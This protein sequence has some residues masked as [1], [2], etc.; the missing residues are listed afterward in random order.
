MSSPDSDN[1]PVYRLDAL[2]VASKNFYGN[3]TP[4]RYLF[5]VID[6]QLKLSNKKINII[7]DIHQIIK[8]LLSRYVI[9]HTI[10]IC[11]N[12]KRIR[13]LESMIVNYILHYYHYLK[14]K[15]TL[16]YIYILNDVN[17]VINNMEEIEKEK[18][19][20]DYYKQYLHFSD[21]KYL[22]V[23]KKLI[24]DN[25]LLPSII[26]CIP[27]TYF[28]NIPM[29]FSKFLK[30]LSGSSIMNSGHN[31]ILSRKELDVA[32]VNNQNSFLVIPN[33]KKIK[34]VGISNSENDELGSLLISASFPIQNIS[35]LISLVSYSKYYKRG[36][37]GY[38]FKKALASN[39]TQNLLNK[40][41]DILSWETY[42]NDL[43]NSTSSSKDE[44]KLVL[45]KDDI[46]NSEKIF[47]TFLCTQIDTD[48]AKNVIESQEVST[49]TSFDEL[50]AVLNEKYFK[51]CKLNLKPFNR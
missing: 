11:S 37:K 24:S 23:Y 25:A 51:N 1:I 16:G 45:Y 5:E 47:S 39:L 42:I 46:V 44:L 40:N 20:E 7:I 32:F 6:K 14:N 10:E 34:T 4:Y 13:H 43:T 48:E 15:N 9:E 35:L 27:N 50:D 36:L 2:T 26:K 21:S 28:V 41:Y 18:A 12:P 30:N 8:P 49:V 17:H 22:E 19:E 29:T 3:L 38:S 31:V 33:G